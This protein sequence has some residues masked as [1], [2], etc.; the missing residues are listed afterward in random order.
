[1]SP[2]FVMSLVGQK[3]LSRWPKASCLHSMKKLVVSLTRTAPLPPPSHVEVDITSWILFL[4]Q[5]GLFIHEGFTFL[6]KVD[7]C[8]ES[9]IFL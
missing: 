3:W 5:V 7:N 8:V 1:M 9:I 4:E 2:A 6:L